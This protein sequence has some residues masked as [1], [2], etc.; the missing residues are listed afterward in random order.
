MLSTSFNFLKEQ[1]SQEHRTS[2]Q[3]KCTR[4]EPIRVR[5][6]CHVAMAGLIEQEQDMSD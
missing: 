2:L 6:R 5:Q 1:V 4:E 3:G